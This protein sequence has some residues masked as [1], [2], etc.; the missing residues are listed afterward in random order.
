MGNR[1]KVREEGRRFSDV[2]G[3]VETD[4]TSSG[5]EHR[6]PVRNR[7]SQRSAPDPRNSS[8]RSPRRRV[9]FDSEPAMARVHARTPKIEVFI[10]KKSIMAILSI[11]R[12]AERWVPRIDNKKN[13]RRNSIRL[14]LS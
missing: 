1:K 7:I 3:D 10:P 13:G 5:G 12:T 9:R 8:D 2:S 6:M 4:D 14:H 11:G